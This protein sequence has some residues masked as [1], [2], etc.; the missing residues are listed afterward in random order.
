[1]SG[2]RPDFPQVTVT[3]TLFSI[4][5]RNVLGNVSGTSA[6]P[7]AV[8]SAALTGLINQFTTAASGAVPLSGTASATASFLTAGG[9]FTT[10]PVQSFVLLSTQT[11]VLAA[12]IA[13]TSQIDNTFADYNFYLEN[14]VPSVDDTELSVQYSNNNGTSYLSTNY[15]SQIGNDRINLTITTVGNKISNVAGRGF[16]GNGTLFNPS[17]ITNAKTYK[18]TSTYATGTGSS[19]LSNAIGGFNTTTSAVNGIRFFPQTGTISGVVRMYG[20]RG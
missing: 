15:I 14:I 7:V 11:A 19:V 2:L 20:V 10:V 13:F 8:G 16:S 5:D 3:G 12:Q 17:G 18:S 1:M 6:L 4:P 9:T